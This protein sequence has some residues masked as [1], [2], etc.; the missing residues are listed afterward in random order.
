MP[1]LLITDNPL[2]LKAFFNNSIFLL[3]V[4]SGSTLPKSPELLLYEVSSA[5]P[6]PS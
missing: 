4:C 3:K 6:S 2:K 5:A 1:R